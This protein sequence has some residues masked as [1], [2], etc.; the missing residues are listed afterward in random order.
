MR[1]LDTQG[2]ADKVAVYMANNARD[3]ETVTP[4]TGMMLF[5]QFQPTELQPA[6]YE[7]VV[8]LILQGEK[9]AIFGDTTFRVGRGQSLVVSHDVPVVARITVARP[10]E[11][12]LAMV[13][14]LDL[15]LLRGLYEEVGEG[16]GS[17]ASARSAA[18]HDA[19]PRLIDCLARYLELADD[20]LEAK[21][22]APLVRRELHF[23]LL[24]APH[25]G[26]LRE[27]LRHDSHASTITRAI[28]RIRRDF[29]SAIAVPELAKEIGMSESA[30][31]KHFRAITSNTPLQYQKELRLMEAKRLLS[32]GDRSV[33]TVAYEV[34]Y[35]SPNQFSREYARKFGVPPS[36]HASA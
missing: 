7:P 16:V 34:G 15:S 27:L 22:M 18:V 33:S 13:L 20:P 25:G 1:R 12:Y 2:L 28:S 36:T 24:M 31:Y 19:D 9:E 4:M 8:C 17:T 3:E 6:L 35:E 23:R 10:S 29:R 14:A 5:R 21:V 11:P 32:A 30:F 26:M